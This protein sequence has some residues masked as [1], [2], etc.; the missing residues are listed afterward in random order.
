M[1]SLSSKPG[2]V[3]A[4]T[5]LGQDAEIYSTFHRIVNLL[6]VHAGAVW[7]SSMIAS[8]VVLFYS[9]QQSMPLN[10]LYLVS[11]STT[12]SLVGGLYRDL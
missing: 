2:Q 7:D 11:C 4:L 10:L 5:S 3:C 6:P 8:S 12:R 9:D 1:L